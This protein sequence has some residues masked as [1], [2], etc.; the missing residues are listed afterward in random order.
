MKI[1]DYN[2]E[3]LKGKLKL[4]SMEYKEKLEFERRKLNA[5]KLG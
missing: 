4:N 5:T 2:D 3:I 1:Q